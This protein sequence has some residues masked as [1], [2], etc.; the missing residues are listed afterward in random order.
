MAKFLARLPQQH[1]FLQ[2]LSV[3][4]FYDENVIRCIQH[5]RP[6]DDYEVLR[7]GI[8]DL[9]KSGPCY[10]EGHTPVT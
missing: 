4:F 8:A 3:G 9:F 7:V 6:W 1:S 10:A 2:S 5:S